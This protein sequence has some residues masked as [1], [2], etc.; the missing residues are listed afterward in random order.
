MMD[1]IFIGWA[2]A[3][4]SRE[5]EGELAGQRAAVVAE[6]ARSEVA[7]LRADLDRLMLASQAMWDILKEEHGYTEEQLLARITAVD[8]QDGKRDG[9]VA[10]PGPISCAQ[11]GRTNKRTRPACLYCGSPLRVEPFAR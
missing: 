10:S 1:G 6:N 11:C 4:R 8:M 7:Q 9:K 3:Q 2:A 5:I